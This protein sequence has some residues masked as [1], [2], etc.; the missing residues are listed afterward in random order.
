M[1]K[2]LIVGGLVLALLVPSAF[3]GSQRTQ[4]SVLCVELRGNAETRRDVKLRDEADANAG[5]E[6][7][8]FR[9]ACE[10]H[11]ASGEQ[12]GLE[13]NAARRENAAPQGRKEQSGHRGRS[14]H[15]GQRHSA[16]SAR[17]IS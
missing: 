5:S 11:A 4:A 10:A 6:S 3:A 17:S 12:Q 1:N 2:T 8:R 14:G 15:L 9:V 13:E 16:H 7:W